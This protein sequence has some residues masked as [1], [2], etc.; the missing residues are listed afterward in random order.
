MNRNMPL[1]LVGLLSAPVLVT[2]NE[3]QATMV[4]K[5]VSR[6]ASEQNAD[7][8]LACYDE[9]ARMLDGRELSTH[10]SYGGNW[11]LESEQH[12]VL[13]RTDQRLS[14]RSDKPVQFDGEAVEEEIYPVLSIS[15]KAS[16]ASVSLNWKMHLGRGSIRMRT[17]FDDSPH[18][19][20]IWSIASDYQTVLVRGSDIAF[21]K[22][23]ERHDKLTAEITPFGQRPVTAQF[24][25]AGLTEAIEPLAKPCNL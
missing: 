3:E 14:V 10:Q 2:G 21:I 12:P 24:T 13:N 19:S 23:M 18:R 15:C 11:S 1:L 17:H 4:E 6:C 22:A 20:E 16:K 25:I 8:R 7:Q 9:L 5:E